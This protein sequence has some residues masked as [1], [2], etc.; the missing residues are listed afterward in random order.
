MFVLGL[1]FGIVALF[2]LGVTASWLFVRSQTRVPA[3]AATPAPVAE[4]TPAAPAEP[5][6]A[7]VP[8]ATPEAAP[9]AEATPE[10]AAPA[11]PPPAASEAT[12]ALE[13]TPPGASV[14]VKGKKRGTTPLRLKVPAGAVSLRVEKEGYKPWSQELKVKAGESRTLRAQLESAATP[15]PVVVA[16]PTPAPRTPAVKEGDLVPL[17]A[18]VTA[19]RRTKGDAA[20]GKRGLAG[21]V[22]IEFTVGIDGKPA[23][24]KVIESAGGPLDEAAM[25]AVRSYRYEPATSQ[26]VKV[27]VLQRARFTFTR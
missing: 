13:S 27:R 21:T 4:A 10:P 9:M 24:I 26:G 11:T 20:Q 6:P 19:P 7:P 2:V 12:L 8:E 25:K 14:L 1:G 3:P 5:A 18:D 22:L 15:P 16:T 23:D 17:G